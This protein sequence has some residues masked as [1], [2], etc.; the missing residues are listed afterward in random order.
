MNRLALVSLGLVV[1]AQAV[2]QEPA[3]Q[4]GNLPIRLD[5][6]AAIVG[7]QI[8][9]LNERRDAIIAKIQRREIQQPTDS[10]AARA[11]EHDVLND[12]IQD[13]LIIQ[14]AKDLKITVADA[15]V[16]PQVDR[17]LKESRGM[18]RS[19]AEF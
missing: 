12:M 19:E 4:P 5:G 17:Q 9:T 3:A 11:I 2:A 13:E 15:D 14:K 8:I 10:L 1:A 16:S 6:I 7:D 18:F